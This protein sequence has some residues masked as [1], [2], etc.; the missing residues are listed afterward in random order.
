MLLLGRFF[1]Y[2]LSIRI[3]GFLKLVKVAALCL[4]VGIF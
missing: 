1:Q 2:D 3:S 4:N